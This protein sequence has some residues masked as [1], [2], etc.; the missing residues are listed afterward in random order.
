[1]KLVALLAL[2]ATARALVFDGP[3]ATPLV[4]AALEDRTSR[5]TQEAR[6]VFRRGQGSGR[7]NEAICGY[8]GGDAGKSHFLSRS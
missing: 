7:G 2:C 5:P 6:E 8:L 3:L 1:M 4:T